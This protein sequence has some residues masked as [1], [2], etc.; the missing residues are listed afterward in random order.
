MSSTFLSVAKMRRDDSFALAAATPTSLARTLSEQLT[1]THQASA[2]AAPPALRRA[3]SST[4]TAPH[5]ASLYGTFS[6]G[7]CDHLDDGRL[8]QQQLRPD[9]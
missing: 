2:A 1:L 3:P 5:A 7:V 6:F 8:A 9:E 4:S